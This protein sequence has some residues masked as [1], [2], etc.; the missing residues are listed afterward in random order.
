MAKLAFCL[1]L[2]VDSQA[3]AKTKGKSRG[4]GKVVRVITALCLPFALPRLI[5]REGWHSSFRIVLWDQ[6]PR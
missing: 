3:N 1:C 6:V 5:A 4:E 2:I